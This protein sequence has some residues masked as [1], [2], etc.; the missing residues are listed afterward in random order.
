VDYN[1]GHFLQADF[2]F[3]LYFL[4]HFFFLLEAQSTSQAKKFSKEIV[5]E[6]WIFINLNYSK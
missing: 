5:G 6:G 4:Q 1:F 2:P 3:F